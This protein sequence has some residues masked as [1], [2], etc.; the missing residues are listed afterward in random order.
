MDEKASAVLQTPVYKK[1][2]PFQAAE[3]GETWAQGPSTTA[4]AVGGLQAW[5]AGRP[6]FGW[7]LTA[8][9]TGFLTLSTGL[10]LSAPQFP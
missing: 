6:G 2:E 8:P 5:E 3:S 7:V 4:E 9:K 1:T 10:N